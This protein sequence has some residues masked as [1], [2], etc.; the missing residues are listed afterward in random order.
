MF[1][2]P[3]I[4]GGGVPPGGTGLPACPGFGFCARRLPCPAQGVGREKPK[5]GQTG[6]S[7]LRGAGEVVEGELRVAL[8]EDAGAFEGTDARGQVVPGFPRGPAL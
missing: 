8:L 2:P 1:S 3:C 4:P 5:A 6:T 7:V